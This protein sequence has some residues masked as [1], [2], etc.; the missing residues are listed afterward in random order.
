MSLR[1]PASVS[2]VM[3][4]FSSWGSKG[5][6][7]PTMPPRDGTG[8]NVEMMNP[9]RE[10]GLHSPKHSNPWRAP[11]QVSLRTVIPET[12]WPARMSTN[13]ARKSGAEEGPKLPKS[14]R[15]PSVSPAIESVTS[16]TFLR[17]VSAWVSC[18]TVKLCEP[19][20]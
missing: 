15:R 14:A 11:T 5:M 6:V 1:I 2:P 10:A 16:A 18:E 4:S 9:R 3:K 7:R 8:A 12:V 20:G 17:K 19:T 13:P